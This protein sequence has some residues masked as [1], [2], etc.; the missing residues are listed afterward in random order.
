MS[1]SINVGY[2]NLVRPDRVVAIL[3]AKSLPVKRLRDRAVEENRL[4]DA[5]AGRKM[6]SLI[7]LDSG[8]VVLSALSPQAVDDR[9]AMGQAFSS[10]PAGP[11]ERQFVS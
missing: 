1:G 9:I 10:H 2:G 4:I 6:R 8:H 3:E 5:T 7:V 11:E